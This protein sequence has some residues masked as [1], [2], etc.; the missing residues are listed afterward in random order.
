MK[1]AI[2]TLMACFC[3]VINAFAQDG[4]MMKRDSL[5]SVVLNQNRLLSVFL[6]EGY[7]SGNEKYPVIYVLDADGRCQHTVPAARF[8]FLNNKMPKAIVVGG[9]NLRNNRQRKSEP[10]V[11]N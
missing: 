5:Q 10:S 8:L 11:H 7:E 4:Y 1:S 9:F 2:V 3:L 6:P